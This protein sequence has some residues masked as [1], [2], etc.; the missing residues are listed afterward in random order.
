LAV[1][2]V[3]DLVEQLLH[4]RGWCQGR[5]VDRAGRLSLDGAVDEAAARIAR[6]E[7]ARL[8]LAGRVRNQ[9][10]RSAGA[11]SL[12]AWN[13]VPARRL[14]EIGDLIRTARFRGI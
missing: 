5:T 7:R 12:S 2:E 4:E 14:A 11:A 3:L 8:A 1:E 10:C 6:S 13:D 9:L